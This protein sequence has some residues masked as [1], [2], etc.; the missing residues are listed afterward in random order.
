V[1]PVLAAAVIVA[2][3]VGA[4]ARFGVARVFAP[5]TVFPWA[6]LVV[7][8]VGS[9]LGGAVLAL[10]MRGNVSADIRLIIVTGLCGGLTTFSTMSVETIQLTQVGRWRTA[11]ASIAANLAIGI[12][13]AAGAFA[14]VM[15]L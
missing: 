4:A 3:A 15:A 6:V 12:G 5:R 1:T 9:A 7:N 14:L 8:V 11:L 10:A 13:C 2:G